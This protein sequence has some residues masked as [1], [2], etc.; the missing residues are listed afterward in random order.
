MAMASAGV[1]AYNGGLGFT[2]R[3]TEA[4]RVRGLCPS[5]KLKH[6]FF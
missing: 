3:A 4:I 6:L 2:D 1:R 5:L